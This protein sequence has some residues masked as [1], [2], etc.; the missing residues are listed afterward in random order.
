MATRLPAVERRRQL[1][2]A[3]L[4]VFAAR[5]FYGTSMDELAE[6]AGVTKPVFYKHFGSKRSLYLELLEDVGHRL[7]DEI[8]KV[9]AEADGPRQQ[10]ERGFDAYFRFIAEDEHAFRLLFGGAQRRGGSVDHDLS[11]AG[12]RVE[13]AIAEAIAPLIDAPIDDEHRRLLAQGIVG[14][15]EA[16][17]RYWLAEGRAD[18]DPATLSSRVAALAWA[19]L[20]GVH[21]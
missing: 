6:T 8:T 3:A 2:D 16:T 14:L 1:L 9:T 5:G 19:G 12:R 10:V 7:I 21:A 15:A 11:D 4:E 20:R 17:G 13:D 18:V